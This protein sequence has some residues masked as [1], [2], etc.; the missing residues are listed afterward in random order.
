[1]TVALCL[2]NRVSP[3]EASVDGLSLGSC[4]DIS[5]TLHLHDEL[6]PTE[7]QDVLLEALV[8]LHTHHTALAQETNFHFSSPSFRNQFNLHVEH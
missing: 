1:M 2:L 3:I 6:I 5:A 8:A 7:P 4:L